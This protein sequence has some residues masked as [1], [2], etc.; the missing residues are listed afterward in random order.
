VKNSSP[1]RS[2]TVAAGADTGTG[3]A[4]EAAQPAGAAV[5]VTA[6]GA[7]VR[8]AGQA[9]GE[10]AAR[11]QLTA[12]LADLHPALRRLFQIRPGADERASWRPLT[13]HQLEALMA[14][15]QGSLT[16]GELCQRLDIAESAGTALCDRLAARGLVERQADPHDRR[17]VRL[18]LSGRARAMVDTFAAAK[19]RHMARVLD[20]LDTE[21]LAAMVAIMQR[22]VERSEGISDETGG[23]QAPGD[24]GSDDGDRRKEQAR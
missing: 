8:S 21:D 18:A 3:A 12:T 17:V 19:R 7:A 9:A 22:L 10:A 11:D 13:V 16:M 15:D 5:A 1:S 24:G 20:V 23:G 4:D 6:A 14:L 2:S